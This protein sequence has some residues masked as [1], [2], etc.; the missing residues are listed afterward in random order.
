M[1][2]ISSTQLKFDKRDCVLVVYATYRLSL[3]FLQT[4]KE[5]NVA[6]SGINGNLS[7]F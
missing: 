5:Q 3:Q 1:F 7:G 4:L 2:K 6:L